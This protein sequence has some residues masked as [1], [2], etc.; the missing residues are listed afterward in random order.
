MLVELGPQN[1]LAVSD[2]DQGAVNFMWFKTIMFQV[3]PKCFSMIG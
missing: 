3:T 1:L 2:H